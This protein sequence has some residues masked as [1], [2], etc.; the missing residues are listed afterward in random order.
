LRTVPL[1][2]SFMGGVYCTTGEGS[3]GVGG[4]KLERGEGERVRWRRDEM[5]VE[6]GGEGERKDQ[7]EGELS[8]RHLEVLPGVSNLSS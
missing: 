6:G 7:E 2:V 3:R 1:V 8:Y 4:Q 5:R